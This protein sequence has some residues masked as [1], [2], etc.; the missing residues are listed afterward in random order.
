ML[1]QDPRLDVALDLGGIRVVLGHQPLKPGGRL[2]PEVSESRRALGGRVESGVRSPDLADLRERQA[3]LEQQARPCGVIVRQ[4]VDRAADEIR[5]GRHVT[6]HEGPLSGRCQAPGRIDADGRP[7]LVER[8]KL[9]EVAV[10]LLEVVAEDLLELR[11]P[12]GLA[13]GLVRPGHEPLVQARP[14]PLQESGV[15][16]VPDHQVGEAVLVVLGVGR[17]RRAHQLPRRELVEALRD[18]VAD[19]V[20]DDRLQRDLREDQAD[21]RGGID[22]CPFALRQ[23]VEAGCQQRVDRRWDGQRGQVA[24]RLPPIV[25]EP[26]HAALLEHR[27]ELLDEQRVALRS[28]DDPVPN[29]IRQSDLAEEVLGHARRIRVGQRRQ[30]DGPFVRP[31]APR[32]LLLQE[33][34]AGHA[35]EQDRLVAHVRGQVAEQVEKRRFGP[36]DV[37]EENHQRFAGGEDLQKPADPPEEL[38]D[39]ERRI[40][41]A[42]GRRD[43]I[44]H[45]LVSEDAPK[46]PDGLGRRVRIEQVR[47]AL[48]DLDDGPEGDAVAIRKAAPAHDGG[49]GAGGFE[50]LLRQARLADAG[51]ADEGDHPTATCFDGR[52]ERFRQE[53]HLGLA[54]DHGV[55]GANGGD[56][57]AQDAHEPMGGNGLRF[58]LERERFDLFESR[59]LA[60]QPR[61]Q[62]ADQDL[63]GGG[64]LFEAGRDVDGVTGHE[65]LAEARLAR[66]DL[67]GVDADRNLEVDRRIPAPGRP[68]GP[69]GPRACPGRRGRRAT[70]RPRGGRAGR[71]RPSRHRR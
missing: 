66:N 59:G 9:E 62:V 41:Q 63:P 69:T 45:R 17:V 50:E 68:P 21:D 47:G 18:L 6:A 56:R 35:Q 15:G 53:P 22:G 7:V 13:I 49:L 57:C 71:R 16:R 60:D 23:L 54:A 48:D 27:D 51:V 14:R 39:L 43:P 26:Q 44:D 25:D 33:R 31:L 64:G 10:R 4:Q 11:H 40:A 37:V 42:D 36:L 12:L 1:S 52:F 28:G 8:A 29:R 67:P 70:H 46:L 2:E 24:G 34:M 19:V 20:L 32:R 61:G 5:C 55:R 30:D 65:A 58:A 38:A 3:E